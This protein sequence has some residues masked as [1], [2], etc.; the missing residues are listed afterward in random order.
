MRLQVPPSLTPDHL[1]EEVTGYYGTGAE[2]ATVSIQSFYDTF[3]WRLY[4]RGLVLCREGNTYHLLSREASE[5]VSTS[6]CDTQA[7]P[8]FWQEFPPGSLRNRL[9]I[10]LDIRA[11][12]HLTSIQKEAR[13]FWVIN[14]LHQIILWV[15]WEEIW[16]VHRT[17]PIPLQRALVLEP[18]PG[19]RQEVNVF[20]NH[21]TA[22]E[23]EQDAPDEFLVVLDAIG[24]APGS[25]S[26]KLNIALQPD[27]PARLATCMILEQLLQTIRQNQKGI[28]L[29]I[30]SEFLH[31]FRVAIRRTRVVL[32][33]IKEV[34]PPDIT[35]TYRQEFAILGRLTNRLRDLDVYLLKQDSYRT[36]LPEPLWP[37]LDLIFRTFAA[38]RRSE[39]NRVVQQL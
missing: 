33:Q 5:P 26:S 32:N 12:L 4:R 14:G 15:V 27:M 16:S 13:S 37:G 3:D 34:L 18:A 30:D 9:N 36:M 24:V 39:L 11:L 20:R 28:Q 7:R 8:C 1:L 10:Y 23:I 19:H 17:E 25:Y 6:T 29:D 21:L 38:E 2:A 31:D 35:G 22:L